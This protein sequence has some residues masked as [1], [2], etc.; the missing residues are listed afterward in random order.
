[1]ASDYTFLLFLLPVELLLQ[2]PY[3]VAMGFVGF[4]S[5]VFEGLDFFPAFSEF[6]LKSLG[7]VPGE[8]VGEIA[9]DILSVGITLSFRLASR[10]AFAS[11]AFFFLSVV[12]IGTTVT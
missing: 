12:T 10:W 8:S 5:P 9:K 11:L 4:L 7:L 1:M 6:C 2:N 3:A